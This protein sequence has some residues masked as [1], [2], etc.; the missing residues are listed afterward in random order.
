MHRA[1]A[2][3]DVFKLLRMVPT[4]VELLLAIRGE[5][6]RVTFGFVGGGFWM[7]VLR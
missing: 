3:E 7:D 6:A 5:T 2:D 1:V 4:K